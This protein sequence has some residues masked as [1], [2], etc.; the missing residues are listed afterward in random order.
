MKELGLT[1]VI[2]TVGRKTLDRCLLSLIDLDV[3]V[4]V[5]EDTFEVENRKEDYYLPQEVRELVSGFGFKYDEYDAGFHDWGY[6]QLNYG[7]L[8]PLNEMFIMNMGDDDI[9]IPE[10]ITRLLKIVNDNGVQPYMFQAILY[11][12]PH[13]GNQV[14]MPLWND[15]C[16]SI[17]R[18]KVTGQNLIV[19]KIPH[20]FGNM[21]DD[22]EF[23]RQTIDAW[24]GNVQWVPLPIV[25]C[26]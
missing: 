19:P 9:I 24:N 15:S 5:V 11:P 23:I 18:S 7:Y 25:E 6:P 13:R 3:D 10:N 8:D 2:P 26:H 21:T 14:P 22:F 4:L 12:S 17:V 1:I 16:R 20:L